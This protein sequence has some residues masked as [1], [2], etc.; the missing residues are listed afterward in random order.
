MALSMNKRQAEQTCVHAL[1]LRDQY[2]VYG[3]SRGKMWGEGFPRPAV[4]MTEKAWKL[5]EIA[6]T[7]GQK[8]GIKVF[9]D[10]DVDYSSYPEALQVFETI[11]GWSYDNGEIFVNRKRRDLIIEKF[12]DI[13]DINFIYEM[14]KKDR[15]K[16]ARQ[17]ERIA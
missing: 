4:E 9:L 17:K 12:G 3:E 1:D 8:M 14:E 15:A 6:R 10:P 13:L 7:R 11:R 16:A 5:N 2:D